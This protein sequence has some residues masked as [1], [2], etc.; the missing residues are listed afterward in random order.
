VL[1]SI[2]KVRAKRNQIPV[3]PMEEPEG[4]HAHWL[5]PGSPWTLDSGHAVKDKRK[6]EKN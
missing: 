6:R 4:K 3:F 5:L 1:P 2:A